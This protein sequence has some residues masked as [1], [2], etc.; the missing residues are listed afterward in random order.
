M[1][2]SKIVVDNTS[3]VSVVLSDLRTG[4]GFSVGGETRVEKVVP[5]DAVAGLARD[6]EGLRER[7]VIVQVIDDSALASTEVASSALSEAAAFWLGNHVEYG[8]LA[9]NPSTA[10]VVGLLAVNLTAGEMYVNGVHRIVAAASDYA[11]S[12]IDLTGAAAVDL[13]DDTE[14]Y[15]A[16]VV[17]SDPESSNALVWRLVIGASAAAGSGLAEIVSRRQALN[18]VQAELGQ[19]DLAPYSAIVVVAQILFEVDGSSV[20]TQTTTNVRVSPGNFE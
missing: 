14:Q 3:S 7:G 6:A 5:S 16:L 18:A 11:A 10:S 8:V 12:A 15:A 19:Q 9:S 4:Y 13:A 1:S 2:T 17:Y 20:V